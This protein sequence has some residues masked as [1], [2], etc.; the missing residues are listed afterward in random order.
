MGMAACCKKELDMKLK[1]KKKANVCQN[2]SDVCCDVITN[3]YDVRLED[4]ETNRRG[5]SG[6]A[7]HD[8][9]RNGNSEFEVT[10][11]QEREG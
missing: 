6:K 7:K 10:M 8:P 3:C 9:E 2:G 11:A 5:D 1:T 4:E